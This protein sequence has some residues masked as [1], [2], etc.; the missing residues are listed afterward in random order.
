MQHSQ[1]NYKRAPVGPLVVFLAAFASSP[2]SAAQSEG[3]LLTVGT[4]GPCDARLDQPDY[5]AGVDVAG[6]PVVPADVPAARNPVPAGALV[7]LSRGHRRGGQ[8]P[9]AALDGKALDTLLNPKPACAPK[10]R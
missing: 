9:I 5:V 3:S 2:L 8:G 10:T 4:P 1:Q 7:P 6:N